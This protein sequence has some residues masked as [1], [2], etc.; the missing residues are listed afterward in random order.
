[1]DFNAKRAHLDAEAFEGGAL[2]RFL[3]PLT[4]K[5]A[6]FEKRKL[7]GEMRRSSIFAADPDKECVNDYCYKSICTK[8][9]GDLK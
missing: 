9:L 6:D 5:Y 3:D 2:L 4:S 8:M 7:D 1:M